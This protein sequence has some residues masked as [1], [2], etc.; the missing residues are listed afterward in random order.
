MGSVMQFNEKIR[1]VPPQLFA[2]DDILAAA[3]DIACLC[4]MQAAR[5]IHEAISQSG[6]LAL[7]VPND[8][9]GADVTND[10]IAQVIAIVAEI[11]TDM[12]RR[13]AEHFT[14]LEFIR[15]AGSDEQR[16]VLFH[17]ASLGETFSLATDVPDPEHPV[18]LGDD[19]AFR[20]SDKRLVAASSDTDW[21]VTPAF[22]YLRQPVLAVVRSRGSALAD[23]RL[24][25]DEVLP[26]IQATNNL[27]VSLGSLLRAAVVLGKVQHDLSDM[28]AHVSADEAAGQSEIGEVFLAA[29]LLKAQITRVAA[30]IDAAQVGAENVTFRSVRRAAIT[31]EI[32]MLRAGLNDAESASGLIASL[33]DDLRR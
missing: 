21:I 10:L 24:R 5:Q 14:A 26:L 13:I 3:R 16:R 31:L 19:L 11:D 30:M 25:A 4:G 2:D 1:A 6:L 15:N 17:K 22:N 28:L 18:V 23:G 7:S 29:E 27:P 32:L 9:G 33:G 12:A 8:I 20:F